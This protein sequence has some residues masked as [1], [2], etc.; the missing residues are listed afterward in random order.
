MLFAAVHIPQ[1]NTRAKLQSRQLAVL[2]LIAHVVFCD[3]PFDVSQAIHS[4][5]VL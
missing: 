4:N 2:A 5:V 3:W 1:T